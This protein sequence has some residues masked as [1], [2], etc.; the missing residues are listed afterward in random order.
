MIEH[1]KVSVIMAAYNAAAHISEAIASVQAQSWP[2]WELVVVDDGSSDGT[3]MIL[4]ALADERIIVSHQEN[5]GVSAARNAALDRATGAFIALLD[6]DDILPARSLE[7]RAK[8]LMDRPEL[9]FVDGIVLGLRPEG[10]GELTIYAPYYRGLPFDPLIALQASCFFGPSW[11]IRRTPETSGKRFPPHMR[12]AEDLA[13]YLSMAHAGAYDHVFEPVLHYR[14]GHVS[15]M[16]DLDG[17]E[18]GY[19]Q[20][21]AFVQELHPAPSADQLATMRSRMR[22]IMFLS[23]LKK[24]MIRNALRLKLRTFPA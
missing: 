14:Q 21:Y 1:P 8:M 15:A 2:N 18:R 11:M 19:R 16:S 9:C 12:H 3:A 24:G 17:L 6:A 10:K 23:Y 20:L 13:Y 22:R 7:V 4:N 5:K